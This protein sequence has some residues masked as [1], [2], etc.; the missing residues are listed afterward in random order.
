MSI[1]E[2]LNK[3]I[4]IIDGAMGTM[5]QPYGLSEADFRGE[6]FI[7]HPCE[8]KGNNDLLNITQPLIIKEIHEAYLEAGADIIETNTFSSQVISMADYQMESLVYELNYEGARIAKEAA[9]Q[10]THKNP[11]KPRFVAGAIGPTNRTASLSPDVND[12]GY[13]AVTFDDLVNAYYEQVRGL[14]D[15]GADVLLI[16]TIFDTLNAKAAI[17]AIIQYENELKAAGKRSESI[18]IMISGTITDASGRTLSGQTVEAFLNSINHGNILSIGLNCALGAKEMRPHIEELSEKAGCYVSA[19]PNAGLPNEFGGYDEQPHETAHLIEDFIESGFVNIV[20]GCCGTTPKHIRCIADKAAKAKPRKVPKPE[21]FLRLS[22]LEPITYTPNSVFM[23]IGERTNVTGSPKFAKL[24]LSG[25]FEAALSV[26]RQQVEG[27]AQVID[28]NMDEG[29]L[30]SEAAMTRFLNLIASEPD[31]AKLP[32]MVDSSKWSV[33]EAGLKCLQGKGIVNSISLKEGED[34]FKERATTIMH[35]G[36]AVVV[37][38]F[39]EVGQADSYE[40][41]IEICKRSYDI[42]VNEVGFPPQDI[43]FDPNILTVATGLEEHNNYAVD[44]INATQW[45]KQ[46]LPLAKVS[47]GVSNISFSFRGNNVVREAMHAAFLYHAIKAGLDMGI[48]NA[49]MLEVYEEIDPTLLTYVEDVLLN[50]REDATERLVEFAE[51]VKSKDKAEVKSAEWRS[52]PVEERL[53][54]ALVKGIIEFLDDDVEEAR[55]KYPRPL[56]VIEGPLMD[57]MNIVGD[58]FGAGKMF[59]PQVVKSARV[60]KKAVAYLLPFIEAEKAKNPSAGDRKNAGKI[61]M[62]TVKGDVH[63]I[64]KNIVGVVLA[65]NNFEIIDLGVMVPSQKILDEARKHQVDIIGLSGLITPSLDEMVHVAKEAEREGFKIPIMIG[66]ATTSRIH[67]AVKIAPNYSGTIV[68][69]LDA[70][71]SVTVASNLLNPESKESYAATIRAEYDQARENHLR[72]KSEK[73]LVPIE[74]ARAKRFQ[75]NWESYQAP[76][77]AFLGTKVFDDFPLDDLLPYIDWTPFFHTWELRG[78]YPRILTD[79]TVGTEASKLFDDAKKLLQEIV[80]NKLL[81]AKGVIGF[82]PANTAGDDIVLYKDEERKEILTRIHTLRQQAEK[83][84]DQPYYALSDFIAPVGSRV[85][86]YWGGFAVTTGIGCDKLVAE[87]E[88]NYDDYNS[89]MVKA[90]ADRLAEAFAEKMHEMVRKEYWGYSSDEQLSNEELIKEQ[91]AGIRPAPGYPACPEHTEKITLFNI[92][93][94]EENTGI[95]L[96]ESLAM[97]PTAAVSGF[98]FSHPESRYF[99]VGKLGKDQIEDYAKRKNETVE[100]VERWLGPNLGY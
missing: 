71:R 28:V 15:G 36:A 1:R 31:I 93:D 25:D 70:S 10:F 19:Y 20:G 91:Y 16:E 21:P 55:L 41:R 6:R 59:L 67:A 3:R 27:G 56:E 62:A 63:D 79:K 51:T 12:P 38:A 9:T 11:A 96:T 85:N 23:N 46:N 5:I 66:G 97:H 44:F 72:K 60:M 33:I 54:H 29:M 50:R 82:W 86:D 75:I 77:P 48:V 68:H 92:L 45:I 99:G 76:K 32:I 80:S 26:A 8:V 39:D 64:G 90:L 49:G 13:R 34:L 35:Y 58:L 65:C 95:Y 22:G 83:A 52:G 43:I 88:K 24:I 84:K 2:E 74:E 89:I 7:N 73:K 94:A 61:L 87:Y 14:I 98:Y 37:M 69:V 18:D 4:L 30:D 42:L 40:R 78:S 100:V 57:G 47:G 53:S 81:T 17:F